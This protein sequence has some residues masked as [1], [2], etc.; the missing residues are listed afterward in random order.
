MLRFLLEFRETVVKPVGA[1]NPGHASFTLLA[2]E[3]PQPPTELLF[4]S[5]SA[6]RIAGLP[7]PHVL[8][9]HHRAGPRR[10]EKLIRFISEL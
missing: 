9:L 3:I 6:F 1:E 7:S 2:I 4:F 8:P 10:T 5:I